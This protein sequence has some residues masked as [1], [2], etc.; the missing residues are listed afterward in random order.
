MQRDMMRTRTDFADGNCDEPLDVAA[1]KYAV[2]HLDTLAETHGRD[3][4]TFAVQACADMPPLAPDAPVTARIKRCVL[5]FIKDSKFIA[6]KAWDDARPVVLACDAKIT[7]NPV[8][9]AAA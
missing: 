8:V 6:W 1:A 3:L 7:E 4:L 9:G 5:D 2:M